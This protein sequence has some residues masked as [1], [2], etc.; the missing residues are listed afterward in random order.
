MRAKPQMDASFTIY[1]GL[2][3]G[4]DTDGRNR[5]RGRFYGSDVI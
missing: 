2:T 4:Y 3:Q 1:N 5:Q